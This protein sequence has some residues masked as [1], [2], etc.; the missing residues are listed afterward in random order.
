M[1]KKNA[2]RLKPY[3]NTNGRTVFLNEATDGF[4]KTVP[5]MNT[6]NLSHSTQIAKGTVFRKHMVL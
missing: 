3:L 1:R 6:I 4:M 2:N 5:F